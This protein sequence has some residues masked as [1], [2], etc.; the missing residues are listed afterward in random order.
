MTQVNKTN[1]TNNPMVIAKASL[2]K[3]VMLSTEICEGITKGT[4][5][6]LG[7]GKT[8]TKTVDLMVA[9]GVKSFML[10]SADKGNKSPYAELQGQVKSAIISAFDLDVQ[11]LLAKE[12]KTLSDMEKGVKRY[13]QQQIGSEFAYYRRALVKREEKA[14]AGDAEKST[15]VEMY[16]KCF[17][18]ALE[19]LAKLEN[20]EFD[21]VAHKAM[22]NKLLADK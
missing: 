18:S 11:A 12:S 3:P 5:Q 4:K 1:A 20:C 19:R 6:S 2:V 9:G 22:I 16:F 14:N 8:K 13:W 7:A 10:A 15:P 21:I 17:E